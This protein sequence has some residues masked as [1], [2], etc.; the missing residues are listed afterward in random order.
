MALNL[1]VR[2]EQSSPAGGSRTA[3]TSEFVD[4]GEAALSDAFADAYFLAQ[5]QMTRVR[6]TRKNLGEPAAAAS[7]TRGQHGGN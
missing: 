1:T 7:E 2:C 3:M 5:P 6:I 4:H